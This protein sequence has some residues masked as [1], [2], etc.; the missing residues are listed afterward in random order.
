M[1]L[2]VLASASG[3]PGVTTSAL[4]LALT[5]P[6]PVLL[7]EAD[8]TG[9]SAVLAGYFRGTAA[10][11]GGLIELAWAARHGSLAAALP[12]LT[13]VV[14]DSSVSVLPGVRAH[15]QSRSLT[16]LWEPL[17]A[18]LKDLAEKGQ[19]VVVDAGRLGLAGSPEPLLYG[20]DLLLLTV[21]SDLVALSAARS[22]ADTL[23]S[24]FDSAGGLGRFGMLLVGEGRPYRGREVSKVLQ[25]PV[26][27]S[28]AWD[29]AG[30]AVFGHG[31][32]PPRR[33]ETSA[34]PRSLR[35][36][37]SAIESNIDASRAGVGEVPIDARAVR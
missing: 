10:H 4:G 18:T 21:R 17:T 34:L 9:G 27:A 33:F 2:V 20:A 26:T 23:R 6:R 24:D 25:L 16:G 5:W 30:A 29:P 8:P 15:G 14:P 36:A 32:T 1:A 37:R 22:W 19:D 31:A 3:S 13:V 11:A 7:V 12:A 35:A 28:M